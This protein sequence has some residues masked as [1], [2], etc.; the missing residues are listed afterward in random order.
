MINHLF[1][2]VETIG[3]SFG[4]NLGDRIEFLKTAEKILKSEGIEITSISSI[5]ETNPHGYS[6]ANKFLNQI[7]LGKTCLPP[8]EILQKLLETEKK[9]GRVR[10]PGKTL[11]RTL[12]LDLLFYGNHILNMEN[13][14]IPHPKMHQRKFILLPLHEI[15][16]DWIHPLTRIS[17]NELLSEANNQDVF[18]YQKA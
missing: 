15:S 3:I 7:A 16:P 17:I 4:S 8:E 18:I 6:S 11:D 1:C 10:S 14:I 12:D 9:C 2:V 13:L 5:Y